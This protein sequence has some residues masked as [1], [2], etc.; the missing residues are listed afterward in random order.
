MLRI[1]VLGFK[2][3][4]RRPPMPLPTGERWSKRLRT[5]LTQSRRA[6]HVARDADDETELGDLLGDRHGLAT[7][8]AGEAA[9]R[10]QGELLERGVAAGL[11]DAALERVGTLE[12]AA[13]GGDEPEHR[14]LALGQKAQ[15][16]KAAGARRIVFQKIA[17]DVDGVE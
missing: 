12:L 17:V 11:V 9:L 8:A 14:D 10:A 15:R 5:V 16:R 4:G 7:D 3:G 13:L 2:N 6:P 1:G